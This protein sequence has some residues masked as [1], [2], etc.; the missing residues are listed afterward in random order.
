MSL[1]PRVIRS[2]VVEHA[3]SLRYLLCARFISENWIVRPF[4]ERVMQRETE[5]DTLF[6]SM[7]GVFFR[8]N[9]Y[10][11]YTKRVETIHRN[12]VG[13]LKRTSYR[14]CCLQITDACQSACM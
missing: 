12:C 5:S 8:L 13:R 14:Y 11:K 2:A 10:I 3:N 1:W 9:I 4:G 7:H 6:Q